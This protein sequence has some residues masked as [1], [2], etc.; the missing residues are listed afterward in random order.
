M[1]VNCVI[2]P[3]N[4]VILYQ[5]VSS[6]Y[7]RSARPRMRVPCGTTFLSHDSFKSSDLIG[8]PQR[9]MDTIFTR[10]PEEAGHGHVMYGIIA[11]QSTGP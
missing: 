10:A 9:R 4:H 7:I 5:F 6:I 11:F 2:R 3:D 8:L 1:N